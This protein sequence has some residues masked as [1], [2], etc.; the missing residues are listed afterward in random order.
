MAIKIISHV[1]VFKSTKYSKEILEINDFFTLEVFMQTIYRE[2]T[3]ITVLNLIIFK[4]L[5]VVQSNYEAFHEEN[6]EYNYKTPFKMTFNTRNTA[7]FL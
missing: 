4:T 7:C 1:D 6:F 2:L 3:I 5:Y